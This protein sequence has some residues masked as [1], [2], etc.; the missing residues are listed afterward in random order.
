MDVTCGINRKNKMEIHEK[1]SVGSPEGRR[2]LGR[3]M[4]KWE[5]IIQCIL[6]KRM[7]GRGIDS[8][9]SG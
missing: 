5:D 3:P 1:N 9:N 2:P 6:N 4:P 7:E 8:S